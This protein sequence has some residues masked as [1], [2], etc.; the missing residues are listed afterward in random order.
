MRVMIDDKNLSDIADSIRALNGSNT[1]YK[2]REMADALLVATK[3]ADELTI[4][5]VQRTIKGHFEDNALTTL[6][7]HALRSCKQLTSVSLPNV[8]TIGDNAFYQSNQI[9]TINLPSL[10]SIGNN[11][12]YDC[13]SLTALILSG[14][15]IPTFTMTGSDQLRNTPIANGTGYIYVPSNLIESYKTNSGWLK[16]VAATAFKTLEEYGGQYGNCNDR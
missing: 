5:V 8:T 11:A 10:T 3:G 2:P 1:T 14:S 15:T 16:H 4:A 12:F 13:T 6:G 7:N 9:T